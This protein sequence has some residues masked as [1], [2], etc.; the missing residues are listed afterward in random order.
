MH[1][2]TVKCRNV[3]RVMLCF[4][5]AQLGGYQLESRIT[6]QSA[7]TSAYSPGYC[8]FRQLK[9][10]RGIEVRAGEPSPRFACCLPCLIAGLVLAVKLGLAFCFLG[11]FV[12]G[13]CLTGTKGF[14]LG[15]LGGFW[16]VF[17]L[18]AGRLTT[19]LTGGLLLL[20]GCLE[21]FTG[22]VEKRGCCVMLL[23][24][25]LRTGVFWGR[26]AA[27]CLNATFSGFAEVSG[28]C[29]TGV[30]GCVRV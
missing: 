12:K 30:T 5:T 22:F 26:F 17:K 21:E 19:L 28:S 1:G 29:L 25:C 20:T 18:L 10:V 15:V 8:C 9:L 7:S 2:W 27:G 3:A 13:N 23:I 16:T 11:A 24:G 6:W 4:F 14:G